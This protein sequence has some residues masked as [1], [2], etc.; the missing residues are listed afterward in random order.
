M[1]PIAFSIGPLPIRWY[2]IMMA[3]SMLVGAWI[4]SAFLRKH[5]RDGDL[6]WDGL[7]WII[8]GGVVGA[9]FAYVITNLGL[10]FGPQGKPWEVFAVWHGGLSFHGG[11]IAGLLVA[12]LYFMNKDTAF[13]EVMD[14]FAPGVAVGVILVR[15]GNF[16]NGDILGYQWDGPWAMNFPHDQYHNYGTLSDIVLRHPT[17]LYGVLVGVFCLLVSI[18]L[19]NESWV[20]RRLPIGSAYLGFVITYSLARSVIEDPFRDVPL[21]WSVVDPQIAGYGL[22]TY[23]Q[24]AAVVLIILALWGLTQLRKWELLRAEAKLARAARRE[25]RES[26]QVERAKKR[27]ESKRQ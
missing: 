24:I 6:V 20:T 2:G 19:L 16:M 13:I 26:R 7:V 23:S 9:R 1:D 5:G 25:R 21:M 12:Y 14:A 17:E 22:F 3:L 27:E 10:F 15:L 18:V 8:A 11:I 4:A